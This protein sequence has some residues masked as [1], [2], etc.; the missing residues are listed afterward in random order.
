MTQTTETRRETGEQTPPEAPFHSGVLVAAAREA[1]GW[2]RP[3]AA[4]ALGWTTCRL[5]AVE[6][7]HEPLPAAE[8]DAVARTLGFGPWALVLTEEFFR[9]IAPAG[10][11]KGPGTVSWDTFVLGLEAGRLV[12]RYFE[13]LARASAPKVRP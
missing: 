2:S 9:D 12:A 8:L 1:R 7:G 13:L 3:L 6:A 4:K 11:P 10:F 5:A